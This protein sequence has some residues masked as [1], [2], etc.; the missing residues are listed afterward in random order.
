MTVLEKTGM[1]FKHEPALD[2]FKKA[3]CKVDGVRV[4]FTRKFIEEQIKKPRPSLRCMPETRKTM[5]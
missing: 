1:N 2:L 5:W 4:F 3:G